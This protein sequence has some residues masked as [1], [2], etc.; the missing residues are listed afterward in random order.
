MA[1]LPL[2]L[3]PVSSR[4]SSGILLLLDSQPGEKDD[5]VAPLRPPKAG[6]EDEEGPDAAAPEPFE[7]VVGNYY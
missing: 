3:Q 6:Q 4:F 2:P 1:S 7:W 5:S